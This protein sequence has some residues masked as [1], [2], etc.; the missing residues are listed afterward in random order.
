MWIASPKKFGPLAGNLVSAR[1]RAADAP[2]AAFKEQAASVNEHH[3][4]VKFTRD[5]ETEVYRKLTSFF[6]IYDPKRAR[7]SQREWRERTAKQHAITEAALNAK[8]RKLYAVD[9]EDVVQNHLLGRLVRFYHKYAGNVLEEADDPGGAEGCVATTKS[10]DEIRRIADFYADDLLG[11]E[12]GLFVKHG[13]WLEDSFPEYSSP[14]SDERVAEIRFRAAQTVASV[15][16]QAMLRRKLARKFIDRRL[17]PDI[18]RVFAEMGLMGAAEQRN[19]ETLRLVKRRVHRDLQQGR[20]SAA[21]VECYDPGQAA[22]YYFNNFTEE[23]TWV[24]PACYSMAADDDEMAAAIMIQVGHD[25]AGGVGGW[26]G[27]W[28]VA[29]GMGGGRRE[30]MLFER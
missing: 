18:D 7:D 28:G 24:Q 25:R 16:V 22:M 26:V 15:M 4:A 30:A 11:L 19:A 9:M 27:G 23:V 14:H 8:L 12:Q 5:K 10:P 6:R 1:S 29:V 3:H 21:W 2:E 17:V 20:R 13:R